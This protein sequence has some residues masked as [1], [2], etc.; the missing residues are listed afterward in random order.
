MA[1]K[2]ALDPM[3]AFVRHTLEARGLMAKYEARPAYQGNDYLWWIANPKR[4]DT[5]QKRLAQMLDELKRAN[6]YMK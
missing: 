2:R 5:R 4:E 6:V 3:P 1:L